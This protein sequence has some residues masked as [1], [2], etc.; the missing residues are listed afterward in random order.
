MIEEWEAGSQVWEAGRQGWLARRKD[1]KKI[2]LKK[3]LCHV[4]F[5]FM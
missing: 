5:F 1:K 3:F 2:F 4:F